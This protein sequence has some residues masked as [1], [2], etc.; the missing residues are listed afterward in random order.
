M[1]Q[2]KCKNLVKNVGSKVESYGKKGQTTAK[3]VSAINHSIATRCKTR[4]K[5]QGRGSLDSTLPLRISQNSQGDET[6][7]VKNAGKR[8]K[9]AKRSNVKNANR[10]RRAKTLPAN[11][12][13]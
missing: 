6:R 5:K 12:K 4:G 2:E 10:L 7:N 1:P 13:K 3:N 11:V 9:S 8:K